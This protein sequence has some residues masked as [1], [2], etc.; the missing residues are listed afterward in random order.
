MRSTPTARTAARKDVCARPRIGLR[1]RREP[2]F[3][4]RRKAD[5]GQQRSEVRKREQPVRDG[6]PA[7]PPHTRLAAM[8]LVVES[9]MYGSPMV[10]AKQQQGCGRKGRPRAS[11]SRSAREE[12]EAAPGSR[13]IRTMCRIA[14]CRG[15]SRRV[16]QCAYKY[17]PS[18]AA[19]KN[20][21][22]V[23]HTAA[24]PPNHGRM[25]LPIIGCTSNSRNALR[26]IV[27]A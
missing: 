25:I 20:S 3:H 21:R 23:L 8:E 1:A 14:C 7:F 18:R 6:A 15:F 16:D 17:P 4:Q 10:A 2:R 26:K 27:Q 11:A 13:A 12:S 22:Q 5:Q 24:E 19:W 9:R